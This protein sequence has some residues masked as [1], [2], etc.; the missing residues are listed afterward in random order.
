MKLEIFLNVAYSYFPK[1]LVTIVLLL[2][3]EVRCFFIQFYNKVYERMEIAYHFG[4]FSFELK[5]NYCEHRV[6]QADK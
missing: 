1:F 4:I 6:V 3:L 5:D 2:S